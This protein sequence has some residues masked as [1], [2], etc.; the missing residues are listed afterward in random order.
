LLKKK[1]EKKNNNNTSFEW[2]HKRFYKGK[3]RREEKKMARKH[4]AARSRYG[5]KHVG[6]HRSGKVPRPWGGASTVIA[7]APRTESYSSESSSSESESSSS[8]SESEVSTYPRAQK[9][10]RPRGGG[11]PVSL[12]FDEFAERPIADGAFMEQAF[13]NPEAE[14]AEVEEEEEEDDGKQEASD[15]ENDSP[16]TKNVIP[17]TDSD[18]MMPEDR[19]GWRDS[20]PAFARDS[21]ILNLLRPMMQGEV[22]QRFDQEENK[23]VQPFIILEGMGDKIC[24]VEPP[25]NTIEGSGINYYDDTVIDAEMVRVDDPKSGNLLLLELD[26]EAPGHIDPRDGV[27]GVHWKTGR[28]C[29]L[30]HSSMVRESFIQ[31]HKALI[32]TLALRTGQ[33]EHFER[34]AE[35]NLSQKV[36]AFCKKDV[37]SW[38]E[39]TLC[40]F[41]FCKDC[42]HP[43][44]CF[45]HTAKNM[46]CR[47]DHIESGVFYFLKTGR[48]ER[49]YCSKVNDS[50]MVE[51]KCKHNHKVPKIE[52][53]L[54]ELV[55]LDKQTAMGE[56]LTKLTWGTYDFSKPPPPK[57]NPKSGRKR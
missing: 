2:F 9:T 6:T 51:V 40:K 17:P 50:Q 54:D 45:T 32:G 30:L 1:K 33:L 18:P 7:T 57:P 5:G 23:Y 49:F 34:V 37:A 39:C 14:E 25:E 16:I 29:A 36:C 47:A 42:W 41:W 48:N 3:Q 52:I 27:V 11:P 21:R 55:Q 38:S 20:L 46:C 13:F 12:P 28:L 10:P 53:D 19:Q 44:K 4:V 43:K 35:L 31:K 22:F 8:D 26:P 15:S 56:Y 24:V